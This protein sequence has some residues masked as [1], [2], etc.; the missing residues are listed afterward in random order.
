MLLDLADRA[1]QL[2]NRR[3]PRAESSRLDD[4]K[5]LVDQRIDDVKE[6]VGQRIDV[7]VKEQGNHRMILTELLV[8]TEME[9]P[10]K[11]AEDRIML[12]KAATTPPAGGPKPPSPRARPRVVPRPDQFATLTKD[13]GAFTALADVDLTGGLAALADVDLT[14]G[15]ATLADVGAFTTL[16]KDDLGLSTKGLFDAFPTDLG[17]STKGLFD[18][19]PTD[20][21]LSTKEAP[22]PPEVIELRAGAL[23]SE[24]LSDELWGGARYLEAGGCRREK[25]GLSEG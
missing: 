25:R 17:L 18:A 5:E 15:L 12:P 19:F 24:L 2:A 11:R 7:I 4:V 20:L 6:L 8:R 1:F 3:Q 16:T 21:G 23:Q 14:G 13:V 9:R 10:A 22:P